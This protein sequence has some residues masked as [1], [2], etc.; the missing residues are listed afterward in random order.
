MKKIRFELLATQA[1]GG[2]LAIIVRC[3]QYGKSMDIDTNVRVF[4]D[5]WDKKNGLVLNNLNARKLNQMIRKTVYELEGYELD[6]DGEFTISKLKDIWGCR[7]SS[8][9]FYKMAEGK[10]HSRKDIREGTKEIHLRVLAHLKKY[11]ATCSISDLT[12]DFAKGFL[13]YMREANLAPGTISMHIRAFRSYYNIARKLFGSKVP[14]DTFNF[15]HEKLKDR[16]VYKIKSLTDADIRLLEN[17]ISRPDVPEKH[18]RV[19]HKFLFMSYT[20]VRISDFRSLTNENITYENGGMWLNY[21]S[22]KT[23]TLVR[24]PLFALFDGRAEQIINHYR[25]NLSEL[26]FI[27]NASSFNFATETAARKAGLNKHITAHM[28]RHTCASRLINKDIPVTTIQKIVGHRS[29]KMTMVYATTN[30]NTLVRQLS[31]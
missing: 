10:I 24:I 17:Y 2:M 13:L 9:D 25:A 6:Y 21:T 16:L 5:E 4:T 14:A 12:E 27:Q 29:L 3:T 23:D 20:G 28:A 19:L 15:Y 7:E 31:K 8:H 22:V 26:F 18:I 1:M 30:E 11:Q